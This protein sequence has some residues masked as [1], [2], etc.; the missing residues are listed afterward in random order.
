MKKKITEFTIVRQQKGVRILFPFSQE[1]GHIRTDGKVN[2]YIRPSVS[3]GK[4]V[5]KLSHNDPNIEDFD[6]FCSIYAALGNVTLQK[7]QGKFEKAVGKKIATIREPYDAY[8]LRN[9]Q[10]VRSDRRAV[11]NGTK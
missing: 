9:S 7:F 8:Y 1:Y 11:N 2:G 6:H 5:R 4:G 3:S 10:Q